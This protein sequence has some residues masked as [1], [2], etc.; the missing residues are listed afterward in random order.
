MDGVDYL[1]ESLPPPLSGGDQERIA[2]VLVTFDTLRSDGGPGD[3]V[4]HQYTV[5]YVSTV[6][7]EDAGMSS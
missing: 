5:V 4:Q 1:I 3:S 7:Q 6:L 2:E